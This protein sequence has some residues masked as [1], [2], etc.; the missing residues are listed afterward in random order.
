[1]NEE[2][3]SFH[4]GRCAY[5]CWHYCMMNRFLI[6]FKPWCLI[7]PHLKYNILALA[8]PSVLHFAESLVYGEQLGG[9]CTIVIH[10]PPYFCCGCRQ[11]F[12]VLSRPLFI[13]Q[14]APFNPPPL[15]V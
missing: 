13:L 1:M 2:L 6:L 5:I 10:G 12:G 4:D 15:L 11:R 9:G 7:K 8:K 14:V 3:V